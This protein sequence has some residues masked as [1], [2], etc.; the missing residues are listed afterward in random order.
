MIFLTPRKLVS[1]T[2]QLGAQ[3]TDVLVKERILQ[4]RKQVLNGAHH[5]FRHLSHRRRLLLPLEVQPL[6]P[7]AVILKSSNFN[8]HKDDVI[9]CGTSLWALVDEH[10]IN[11]WLTFYL[12]KYK[13]RLR[14]AKKLCPANTKNAF[15]IWAITNGAF[16]YLICVCVLQTQIE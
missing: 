11:Y 7:V 6:S 10:C 13:I 4:T 3:D 9:Q 2:S 16:P 14:C 5:P 8:F 12:V 15:R 1:F